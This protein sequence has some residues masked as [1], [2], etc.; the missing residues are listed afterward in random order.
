M[1]PAVVDIALID[2]EP[3]RRAAWATRLARLGG[4]AMAAATPAEAADAALLLI[5]AP[6]G[7]PIGALLAQVAESPAVLA[8]IAGT[9][10]A[11]LR[12]A[13][14]LA[15]AELLD[16]GTDDAALTLL[17]RRAARL[18]SERSRRL[19]LEAE[20]RHLAEQRLALR[21]LAPFEAGST[22][23]RPATG[24]YRA[25]HL[26]AAGP[27]LVIT[28]ALD[29]LDTL[30]AEAGADAA[31][32]VEARIAALLAEAPARLGDMLHARGPG[33]G[34]CLWRPGQDR[35]A[36]ERLTL[37]LLDRVA[38]AVQD[39]HRPT[40]SAGIA[41]APAASPA[42]AAEARADAALARAAALG[43]NRIRWAD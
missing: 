31:T 4:R 42:R 13:C 10:T 40:L 5:R 2:P 18:H 28:L 39:G 15:G 32:A 22:L 1:D 33:A 25:Q 16:E 41:L 11:A 17:L 23:L 27:A 9:A 20:K 21:D 6:E 7:G 30:Q 12:D 19:H 24:R 3:A 29:G 14:A 26:L 34:W 36:A 37:V 35:E 43:G 8:V 38:G